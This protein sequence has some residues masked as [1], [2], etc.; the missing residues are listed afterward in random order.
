MRSVPA[1]PCCAETDC[2]LGELGRT[3]MPHSIQRTAT[4]TQRL[5]PTLSASLR[6]KLIGLIRLCLREIGVRRIR[7]AQL[8]QRNCADGLPPPQTLSPSRPRSPR[9]IRRAGPTRRTPLSVAASFA[10]NVGSAVPGAPPEAK[11]SA[12]MLTVGPSYFE[13]MKIPILLGSDFTARPVLADFDAGTINSALY[14]VTVEP[15]GGS[16]SGQPTSAPIYT[17][18]LIETV[19]ATR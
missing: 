8:S 17:G 6:H 7:R 15:A 13:T 19:P 14:A 16:P 2:Y 3:C 5:M 11:G 9:S 4:P 10:L 1:C 18:K 12:Y